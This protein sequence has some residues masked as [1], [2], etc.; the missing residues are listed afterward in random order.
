MLEDP[1]LLGP[2]AKSQRDPNCFFLVV[3][4]KL[5]NLFFVDGQMQFIDC[6]LHDIEQQSHDTKFVSMTSK[7][8]TSA[9]M[10]M[11]SFVS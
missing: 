8:M 1:G 10:S 4:P 5:L 6:L 11:T 7:N 2:K 3:F 9:K